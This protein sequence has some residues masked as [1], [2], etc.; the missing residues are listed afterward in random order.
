MNDYEHTTIRLTKET[1][2]ILKSL[3]LTK[4]DTYEEIILRII[5]RGEPND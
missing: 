4:H 3:K 5:K 1:I 2:E